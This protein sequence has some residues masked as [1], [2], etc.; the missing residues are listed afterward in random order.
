MLNTKPYKGSAVIYRAAFLMAFVVIAGCTSTT[1]VA[2]YHPSD[3]QMSCAE[4]EREFDNLEE[5][6]FEARKNKGVNSA[7][8][9]AAVFFWPAI[10]LNHMDAADAEELVNRRRKRLLDLHVEKS[11][12]P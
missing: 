10:V 8:V 11:C 2:V 4:I 12:D 9:A 1:K 3:Q 7:N 6:M 5:I